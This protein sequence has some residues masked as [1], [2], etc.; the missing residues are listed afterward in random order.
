MSGLPSRPDADLEAS[1]ATVTTAQRPFHRIPSTGSTRRVRPWPRG[2][3]ATL[4]L[5]AVVGGCSADRTLILDAQGPV[6]QSQHDLLFV[7]TVIMLGVVVPVIAMAIG[8]AWRYRDSNTGARYEPA[9]DAPRAIDVVVWTVPTVVVVVLGVMVWIYTH[10]L[11]PYRPLGAG[12][13]PLEIQA[14]ALDWKWLF[15]YPHENI[16]TINELALPVGRPVTLKIT[17][18]TV[19]NS[20][21]IP[22][23]AGQI[24]AMAGM[25]TQLNLQADRPATLTG[26]NAQFSGTGFPEQTFAVH[27]VAPDEFAA[28]V[29]RVKGSPLALDAQAYATLA[30]PS[31]K[32]PVAHYATVQP[33][34][35][36]DII[37]SYS[38]VEGAR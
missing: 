19:M 6:A 10:R 27:A 17:S 14:V 36:R 12:T 34:L 30:K 3:F 32:Q 11:D 8:F 13:R 7:A 9:W 33:L 25:Q 35:F 29:G 26:R 24:Y 38:A 4:A 31:A 23:L 28:W 21:F 22:S 37:E 1:V 2:V 20:L 18:A 5:G 15:I 16:A